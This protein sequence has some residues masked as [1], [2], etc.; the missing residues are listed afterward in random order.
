M[1]GE[2]ITTRQMILLLTVFRLSLI[3]SYMPSL[4]LPPANQDMWIV[5]FLSLFYSILMRIPIL[6]LVNKFNNLS[7]IGYSEKILGKFLGKLVGILYGLY[8]AIYATFVITIQ[9]QLVAADIL[10]NTPNWLIIGILVVTS[11]YI[12][13]KG[14]IVIFR[15]GELI[16]P[17]TLVSIIIL[18][19]LGVRSVEFSTF[20]PILA[21]SKFSEINIGAILLS[22]LI[23]DI[24][25]IAMNA[26]YLENKK[27][28]NKI[29]VKASIYSIL[30]SVISVMV[31]QGTL[32]IEQARHANYPF[33]IYTRLIKYES[34]LQRIDAIYVIT[35]ISTN[36]LRKLI[37][38][39][40]SYMS[41]KEVFNKEGGQWIHYFIGITIGLIAIQ[42]AN[43]KVITTEDSMLNKFFIISSIIF[44]TIIPLITLIVYF[45]RRK[46]LNREE[47][48]KI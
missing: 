7:I 12:G 45:F 16:A 47:N 22:F 2:K 36:T 3:V 43:T 40:I 28:I 37:Y 44:L 31:T 11:L 27:D 14:L 26:P 39:Y 19:V 35:W 1:N 8:F 48:S 33:L 25:I 4:D 20:L 15:T 38:T 21:D 32:G 6:F 13:S 23:T 42:L 9:A 24:F 41:F 29:Y 17:I 46:T 34:I 18:I 5:I 10:P 30:L